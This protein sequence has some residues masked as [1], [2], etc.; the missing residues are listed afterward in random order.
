MAH[1]V[2]WGEA[3]FDLVP[4][5]QVGNHLGIWSLITGVLVSVLVVGVWIGWKAHS[6]WAVW[7]VVNPLARFQVG[8]TPWAILTRKAIRFVSRRR[9][10]G[11]AFSNYRNYS[12]RNT[13]QG[14]PTTLRRARLAVASPKASARRQIQ[15]DQELIPLREGPVI[16]HG[17]HRRRAQ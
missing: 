14:T 3:T 8:D 2:R 6:I 1:L 5:P 12:L 13:E 11:L 7:K 16:S 15:F 10:I 4:G 9:L 17:P